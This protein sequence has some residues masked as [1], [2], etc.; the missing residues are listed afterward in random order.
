MQV[1]YSYLFVCKM[2]Q[3]YRDLVDESRS[4]EERIERKKILMMYEE[5]YRAFNN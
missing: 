4:I 2:I 5:K 1:Y 3:H